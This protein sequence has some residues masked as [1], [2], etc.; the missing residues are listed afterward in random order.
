MIKNKISGSDKYFFFVLVMGSTENSVFIVDSLILARMK[1]YER[2]ERKTKMMQETIQ[3]ARAVRPS[4]S[5]GVLVSTELKMFTIT[6]SVVISKPILKTKHNF[7]VIQYNL[8][9]IG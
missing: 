1:T 2:K 5:P 8:L 4:A 3:R 9:Q 6:S 7:K